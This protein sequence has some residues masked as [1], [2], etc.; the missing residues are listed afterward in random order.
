M[1]WILSLMGNWEILSNWFQYYV[2]LFGLV[3]KDSYRKPKLCLP[4]MDIA[5]LVLHTSA[6]SVWNRFSIKTKSCS[7]IKSH[8]NGKRISWPSYCYNRN[9]H[10]WKD[11][12]VIETGSLGCW[13]TIPRVWWT[14]SGNINIGII[15]ILFLYKYCYIPPWRS[16]VCSK[17]VG[18][19]WREL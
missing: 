8:W 6:K 5:H 7:D 19:V 2:F 18:M 11:G 16:T 17:R 15:T 10:V 4:A 9:P 3:I 14:S 12:I 1:S 13:S